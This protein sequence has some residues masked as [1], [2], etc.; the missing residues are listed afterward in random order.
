LSLHKYLYAEGDPID[1]TDPSGNQI[2]DLV[3][4]FALDATLNAISTVGLPDAL[5][6]RQ[7]RY[8]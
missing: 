6:D 1:H 5:A 3:G 8:C 2:D 7:P 4:S